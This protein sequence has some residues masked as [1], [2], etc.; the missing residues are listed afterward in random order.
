MFVY[1]SWMMAATISRI[2]VLIPAAPI[3]VIFLSII[4]SAQYFHAI[5]FRS[6][7][8]WTVNCGMTCM[9]ANCH[10]M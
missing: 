3:T 2:K 5:L 1:L 4:H 9:H 6:F 10:D 7:I 8:R